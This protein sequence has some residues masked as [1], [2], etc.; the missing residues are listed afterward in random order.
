M[1]CYESSPLTTDPSSKLHIFGHNCDPL[2]MNSTKICI[3]E[4]A[5]QIGLR[6][7]LRVAT[8]LLWNLRSVLKSRAVSRT[9]LWNGSFL[10]KSSVLF[11]YFLISWRATVPVLGRNL[12]GFFTPLVV[13][14][15]F[16]AALVASCF[17]GAFSQ[18]DLRAVCFVRAIADKF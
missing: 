15:D 7:L 18:V 8:E 10:I 17:L 13:G 1:K 5:N 6:R 9:N 3:L 14:A 16:L 12:W 2:S 4:K 11:W